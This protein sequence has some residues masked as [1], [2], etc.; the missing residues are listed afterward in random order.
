MISNEEQKQFIDKIAPLHVK[1]AKKYGQKFPSAGIAQAC[2]ESGYGTSNKAKHNNFH[3]MKYRPNRVTTS[4]GTFVDGG[5]E[6]NDDASYKD[7]TDRWFEFPNM[8][9]E[10][11]GYY[12]FINVP[13]YAK[14]KTATSPEQYLQEIKNAHYASSIDYVQKCVNILNKYNLKQYD[15]PETPEKKESGYTNSPL[16]TSRVDLNKNS[17]PRNMRYADT[18]TVYNPS[19]KITVITPHH[20]AVITT[21]KACAESHKR[22]NSSSANYY[23][24]KDGDICLGVEE[25]YRAWTSGSRANDSNAITIEVSNDGGAPDYHVSDK[26]L[27]SL[28]KLCVD[29]CKRNG[30]KQLNYTGDKTGNLTMHCMFQATACPGPYLKSK[31]PYIMEEVNKRLGAKNVKFPVL[32]KGDRGPLVR[33]LR[34]ALAKKGYVARSATPDFFDGDLEEALK[35]FQSENKDLQGRPLDVD[36]KFGPLSHGALYFG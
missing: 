3:G 27:E 21:G 34:A 17:N 15:S 13:A 11:E 35:A 32:T 28:I 18:Q 4:N 7:I 33:K 12:Q 2:L 23:I 31:F 36:G 29:I 1:Y 22:G 14:V 30:I 5:T 6:Q 16:A 24:G 20:M 9:A 26:A 10:V 19:G 25:Q 8:E